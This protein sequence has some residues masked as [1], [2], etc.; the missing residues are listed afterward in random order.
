MEFTYTDEQEILRETIR[1]FAL[2]EIAPHSLEWDEQQKFPRE[3]I[4]KLSDMGMMGVLV[5]PKY[6]GSGL[7]YPEYV[8]V[9]EELSRVDGS[10]GLSVSA[11]NSLCTNHIYLMGSE[12][13]KKRYLPRLASGEA[14]GAW[15][16]TEPGSGSD[17][18]SAQTRAVQKDDGWVLNGTKSFCTHGSCADIYVILAVTDQEKEGR[19]LSAFVLEKGSKGLA[20]GKKENKL[21]CRSSDTA[22][23]ILE[24]CRVPKENLLGQEGKGFQEALRVL[25]GARISMAAM[26]LGIAQGA[27]DCAVKYSQEREQFG[28]P[29]AKFQ[30][31]QFKLADMAT[32]IEAARLLTYQAAWLKREGKVS[33]RPSSMSKLYAG[34]V[35]VWAAEQAIQ[36]HGGY[37]YT[38]DYPAEKY[39]RD[40]KLCTIG[41]GTSEIQRMIIARELLKTT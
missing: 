29:I 17:A 14:L 25:D 3:A 31:I 10:L 1:E 41:E 21:G 2:R 38:K 30:A 32:R 13:Q 40:S 20:P 26:A 4:K 8:I 39:W 35:A 7:G 22:S 33:P 15:A 24:D 27:L 9:I 34:E 36:I 23:V 5:D 18:A 6:G 11:H 37:G 16:L 12:K 19:A 28:R